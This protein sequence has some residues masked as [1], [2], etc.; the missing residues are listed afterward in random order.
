[1]P[2][3]ARTPSRSSSS[4]PRGEARARARETGVEGRHQPR[5]DVPEDV[6][7]RLS[8]VVLRTFS[9]EDFHRVDMRS[10]AREAGMSF[11]TIYRYFH[12]KEALLFWF[13]AHGLRELYPAAL[14]TLDTTETTLVRVQNYL[15]AHLEFYAR[16]PEVGRV[17]FMTVP[18]QRWIRD[19]TYRAQGPAQRLLEVIAEGQAIG[20][21]R[22]DVTKVVVFDLWSGVFNRAFLMW[23]YRGRSYSLVGQADA[24]CRILLTGIAGPVALRRGRRS[25]ERKYA[26]Q[27]HAAAAIARR[28]GGHAS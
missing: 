16:R 3:R 10:I 8:P 6:V 2:P 23:E 27:T 24:L 25:A 12:D 1:M 20:E 11:A 9:E 13:I 17:I 26:V 7:N 4:R 15:L 28:G 14:A 22:A 19:E 18:L 21:I 5:G